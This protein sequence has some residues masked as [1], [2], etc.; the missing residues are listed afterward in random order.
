MNRFAY[1]HSLAVAVLLVTFSVAF[2]LHHRTHPEACG[3]GELPRPVCAVHAS[4]QDP[5]AIVIAVAGI[6]GAVGLMLVRRD[7]R[8]VKPS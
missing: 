8:F 2:Y 6:A 7:D 5:L 1:Y 3:L 4:W